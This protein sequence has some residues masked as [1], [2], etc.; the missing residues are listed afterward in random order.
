M[1][2]VVLD[3]K[4]IDNG[5][6]DL[7]NLNGIIRDWQTYDSTLDTDVVSRIRDADIVITNKVNLQKSHFEL[8]PQFRLPVVAA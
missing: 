2:G 5:D 1:K 8:A 4:S 6:I 7:A 3:L